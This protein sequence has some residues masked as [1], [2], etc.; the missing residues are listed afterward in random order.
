MFETMLPSIVHQ[1]LTTGLN[2]SNC[3]NKSVL[4][5]S[6]GLFDQIGIVIG[7]E[8]PVVVKIAKLSGEIR[9]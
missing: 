5:S 6:N 2:V 7:G 4:L 1:Y 3:D 9:C 8:A